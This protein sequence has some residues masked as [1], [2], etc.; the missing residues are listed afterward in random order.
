MLTT[1]VSKTLKLTAQ[2]KL[3]GRVDGHPN[4]LGDR[5]GV[6]ASWQTGTSNFDRYK[7]PRVYDLFSLPTQTKEIYLMLSKHDRLSKLKVFVF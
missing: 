6:A 7:K 4:R 2:A 1:A 5:L 3:L